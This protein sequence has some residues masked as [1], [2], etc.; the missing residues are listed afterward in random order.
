M[1]DEKN[2]N[3]LP[4]AAEFLKFLKENPLSAYPSEELNNVDDNKKEFLK[5]ACNVKL[6]EQD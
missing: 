4:S 1:T 6:T 3:S 2:K 5:D